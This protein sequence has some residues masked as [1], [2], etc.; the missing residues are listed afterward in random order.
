MEAQRANGWTI[1]LKLGETGVGALVS[2]LPLRCV[3]SGSVE[4]CS[5]RSRIDRAIVAWAWQRELD[6]GGT[7]EAR[8][9]HFI[10]EGGVWMAY[11]LADGEVRGVY[12]PSHNSQRAERSRAA[13]CRAG[14]AVLE[15]ALAA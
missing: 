15:L 3:W 11:G 4:G 10:W 1:E 5:C 7:R 14:D 13:L 2:E 9:F 12:C 6:A 8:F